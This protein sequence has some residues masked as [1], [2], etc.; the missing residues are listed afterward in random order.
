MEVLFQRCV[1]DSEH[2]RCIS[3]PVSGSEAAPFCCVIEIRCLEAMRAV[4]HSQWI[5]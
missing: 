5:D 4:V 1:N 2:L 3:L